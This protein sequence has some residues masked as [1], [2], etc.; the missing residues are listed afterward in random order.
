MLLA[1][2]QCQNPRA[3]GERRLMPHVLAMAAGQVCNPVPVLILVKRH[4]ALNHT[5]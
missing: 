5:G 3:I 1:A 4:N 2:L